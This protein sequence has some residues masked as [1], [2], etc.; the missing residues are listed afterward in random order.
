MP[1]N[2]KLY[3]QRQI[4]FIIKLIKLLLHQLYISPHTRTQ[5]LYIYIYIYITVYKNKFKVIRGKKWFN[6]DW[7][8]RNVF[9]EITKKKKKKKK[10]ERLLS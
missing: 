7:L 8:S 2:L 5:T 6:Y 3:Q 10:R 1:D 4:S 9:R